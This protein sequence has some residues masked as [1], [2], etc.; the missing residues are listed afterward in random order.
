MS[1]MYDSLALDCWTSVPSFLPP[2]FPPLCIF[3]GSNGNKT[4]SVCCAHL[5]EAEGSLFLAMESER[6][7]PE[8]STSHQSKRSKQEELGWQD[9]PLAPC[10]WLFSVGS[11]HLV[12]SSFLYVRPDGTI[13]SRIT[14]RRKAQFFLHLCWQ[15]QKI[16]SKVSCE[17]CLQCPGAVV[18]VVTG[19]CWFR[20]RMSPTMH[21]CF[22]RH[23]NDSWPTG[24][25][26]LTLKDL[27]SLVGIPYL[28]CRCSWVLFWT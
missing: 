1:T 26:S 11:V 8:E 25:M 12:A 28:S 22:F 4:R 17:E 23:T 15:A 27:F 16:T 18:S 2:S 7:A 14:H 19:N 10:S 20:I 9:R 21:R 13:S 6:M 24:S 5:R 3:F